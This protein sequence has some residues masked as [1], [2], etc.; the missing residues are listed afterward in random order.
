MSTLQVHVKLF[1]VLRSYAPEL[2][3]ELPR[4]TAVSALRGRI[5]EALRGRLRELGSEAP[6]AQS[7]LAQSVLA[8]EHRI[9]G[10]ADV[11]DGPR[12][13]VSL[14]VLPPVCGG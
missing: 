12:G 14:A 9:L 8:D 1:G 3:F 6:L 7:V 5:A 11:V 10:D 13:T 4:G 2:T